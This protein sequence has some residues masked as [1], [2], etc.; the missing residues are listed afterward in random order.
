MHDDGRDREHD[1]DAAPREPQRD[2]ADVAGQCAECGVRRVIQRGLTRRHRAGTESERVQPGR[3]LQREPKGVPRHVGVVERRQNQERQCARGRAQHGETRSG[4]VPPPGDH[5]VAARDHSD[6]QR[7]ERAAEER[8]TEQRAAQTERR[9]AIR[10]H[11]REHPRERARHQ[12]GGPQ[13]REI[14]AGVDHEHR[15]EQQDRGRKT[16]RSGCDLLGQEPRR[17]HGRDRGHDECHPFVAEHVAEGD[18]GRP[19]RLILREQP[20]AVAPEEPRMEELGARRRGERDVAVRQH[21]ALVH[22]DRLVGVAAHEREQVGA[23]QQRRAARNACEAGKRPGH[24]NAAT[25][26]LAAQR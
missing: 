10:A 11:A 25:R 16:A 26:R 6:D 22:V 7:V 13:V 18:H 8:E 19:A 17:H 3:R 4:A 24:A 21:P 5:D 12:C 9:T 2:R 14:Q 20:A 1:P 15:R 23:G